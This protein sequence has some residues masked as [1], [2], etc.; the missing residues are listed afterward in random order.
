MAKSVAS[1]V[2][3]LATHEILPTGLFRVMVDS[4]AYLVYFSAG[5]FHAAFDRCP[6]ADFPLSSGRR[7]ENC[8]V[9]PMHNGMFNLSTGESVGQRNFGPLFMLPTRIVDGY[10]EAQVDT[11]EAA[12]GWD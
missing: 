4:Q 6:H 12:N 7:L 2:R 3:L 5:K 9:C 11:G 1:Y 10:L 8:V